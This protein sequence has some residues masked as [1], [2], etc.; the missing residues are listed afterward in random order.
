MN[1]DDGFSRTSLS[2]SGH[3]PNR[4]ARRAEKVPK[5][6][7]FVRSYPTPKLILQPE[8]KPNFGMNAADL[9]TKYLHSGFADEDWLV[10]SIKAQLEDAWELSKKTEEK[11]ITDLCIKSGRMDSFGRWTEEVKE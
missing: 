8:P 3:P 6:K 11:R 1:K 5:N 2:D 9:V 10:H 7:D 4:A